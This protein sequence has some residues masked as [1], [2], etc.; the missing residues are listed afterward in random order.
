MSHA[1]PFSK[2]HVDVYCLYKLSKFTSINR[3]RSVDTCSNMNK[4]IALIYDGDEIH[5]ENVL[6]KLLKKNQYIAIKGYCTRSLFDKCH[7]TAYRGCGFGL[8]GFRVAIGIF[9]VKIGQDE[10]SWTIVGPGSNYGP[11]FATL[12]ELKIQ[13]MHEVNKHP[14]RVGIETCMLNKDGD[15]MSPGVDA[16]DETLYCGKFK[17]ESC[18]IPFNPTYLRPPDKRCGPNNGIQ[19]IAC[20]WAQDVKSISSINQSTCHIAFEKIF[21]GE[22]TLADLFEGTPNNMK[23]CNGSLKENSGTKIIFMTALEI[24]HQKQ[25]KKKTEHQN[26][27]EK[28]NKNSYDIIG[29]DDMRITIN[30][31]ECVVNIIRHVNSGHGSHVDEGGAMRGGCSRVGEKRGNTPI[32]KLHLTCRTKKTEETKTFDFDGYIGTCT[33][34]DMYMFT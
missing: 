32:Y 8:Q 2:H 11:D 23:I 33:E 4:N 14:Y 15:L 22:N 12:E 27:Q 31:A 20:K 6:C 16:Y 5:N 1:L 24:L 30:S 13:V 10:R 21:T 18:F 17:G 25:R 28:H 26:L 29:I 7:M 19:C 34:C 9:L 3:I